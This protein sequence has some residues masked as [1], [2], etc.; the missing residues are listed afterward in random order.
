[1]AS[2]MSATADEWPEATTI[3]TSSTPDES[4]HAALVALGRAGFHP[5]EVIE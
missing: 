2:A 4:A 5:R 1:V 3:D